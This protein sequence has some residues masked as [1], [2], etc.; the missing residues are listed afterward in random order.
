MAHGFNFWKEPS[1]SVNGG[2][3]SHREKTQ[4]DVGKYMKQIEIHWIW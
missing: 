3:N 4:Q 2:V 1:P